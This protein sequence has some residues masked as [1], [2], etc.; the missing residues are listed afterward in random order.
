M[1]I[2]SIKLCKFCLKKKLKHFIFLEKKYLKFINKQY[3]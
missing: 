3:C 2:N 1:N